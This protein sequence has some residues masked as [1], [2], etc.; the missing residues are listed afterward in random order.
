MNVLR[1]WFWSCGCAATVHFLSRF[2]STGIG[3]TLAQTS[4]WSD[5]SPQVDTPAILPAL[6]SLYRPDSAATE[7][8]LWVMLCA[9]NG[10]YSSFAGEVVSYFNGSTFAKCKAYCPLQ[11]P[12]HTSRCAGASLGWNF[13]FPTGLDFTSSGRQLPALSAFFTL[14][15]LWEW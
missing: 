6:C 2:L 11:L 1:S 14:W 13:P 12:H 4:V 15:W 8:Y 10:P 3:Q 5:R 7:S 9:W